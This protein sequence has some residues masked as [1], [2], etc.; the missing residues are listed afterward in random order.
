VSGIGTK[1]KRRLM[2]GQTS[3]SMS[4]RM[5]R[6]SRGLGHERFYTEAG[7]AWQRAKVV[8][9]ARPPPEIANA[10]STAPARA[11][12][13]NSCDCR[14]A[15]ACHLGSCN[16]LLYF[17]FTAPLGAVEFATQIRV[18][19]APMHD[20]PVNP[21]TKSLARRL[22]D[23]QTDCERIL[24]SR[25]RWYKDKGYHFRRQVALGPYV[26][27][28]VCKEARLIVE[29]D[30]EQHGELELIAHDRARDDWL[31]AQGFDVL[32]Y[33]NTD[34]RRNLD[35][36][37]DGI[38]TALTERLSFAGLIAAARNEKADKAQIADFN[39]KLAHPHPKSL[40]RFR[41]P[42]AGR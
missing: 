30:G 1:A 17:D 42:P 2:R 29:A 6:G 3:A 32:R 13:G 18:G 9:A 23:N 28:F 11:V 31:R 33:A 4:Y 8:S 38:L 40:T 21:R 26:A 39:E 14:I 5:M 12:K 22:R 16:E 19:A 34:I 24:W 37:C 25:L 20:I 10:I 27:D 15:S 7:S 41:P 35:G 36:V